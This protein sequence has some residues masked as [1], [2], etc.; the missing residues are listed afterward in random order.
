MEIIDERGNLFGVV[1][2][3]DAL[4]VLLVLSVLV[5][6]IALID[7]F[8][9][10]EEKTI[11]YVTVDLGDHPTYVAERISEG[12]VMAPQ[13]RTNNLTIT[14]VHPTPGD[15]GNVSIVVRAKVE[16]ALVETDQV[17]GKNFVFNDKVLRPGLALKI[18]TADYALDGRVRSMASEGPNLNTGETA[19][20]LVGSVPAS[21]A[22]EID[23]GDTYETGGETV[24]EVTTVHVAPGRNETTVTVVLGASL[25]TITRSDEPYF[26]GQPLEYGRQVSLELGAYTFT[27]QIDRLGSADVSVSEQTVTVRTTVDAETAQQLDAGDTYRLTGEPVATIESVAVYPTEKPGQRR[28]VAEVRLR[29]HV[30]QGQQRYGTRPVRLGRSISFETNDYAFSGTIVGIGQQ[31][32]T[33][34]RKVTAT[35]KLANVQPEVANSIQIGMV[36]A[37]S[38]NTYARITDK[39]VEPAVVI[40]KSDD[41]NIY[42]REHPRNK[43]VYLTTELAVRETPDG[44]Q[45]HGQ[46]LEVGNAVVLDFGSVTVQGKVTELDE[47]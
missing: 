10:Q 33:D 47:E 9:Q 44:L 29:T 4:V 26:G 24:G 6:G 45:F 46:E 11:R 7:P 27:G 1:N 30:S 28:V 2:V 17:V 40:L 32:T 38:G 18:T 15:D 16:G 41:G 34:T 39:R 19:V 20:T 25:S 14:D 22:R 3:I 37:S 31:S 35:V 42:Q 21:T 36:E 8:Q 12:D 43:D 5:A 13:G 23:V